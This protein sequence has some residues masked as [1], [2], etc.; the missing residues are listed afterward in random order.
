MEMGGSGGW[1]DSEERQREER[2]SARQLNDFAQI[3]LVPGKAVGGG[4]GAAG[5]GASPMETRAA[6]WHGVLGWQGPS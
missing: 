3:L 4:A 1:G 2:E 5:A 6:A